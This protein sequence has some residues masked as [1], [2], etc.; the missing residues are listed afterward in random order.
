ME[1]KP[2]NDLSRLCVHTITTRPWPIETAAEKFSKAGVKGI[3][4]WRDALGGRN[5]SDVSRLL[6]NNGLTVVSLCRGGFFPSTEAGKRKAAI[7]DN[8]RA[9]EEASQLGA[10]L[11][12]LVCG[13]DPNQPLETSRAQI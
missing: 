10:P 11:V 7:D 5:I 13:S 1:A 3:T 4:V 9:I 8:K 2:F 12:V 6:R